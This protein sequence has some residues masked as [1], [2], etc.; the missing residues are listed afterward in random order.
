MQ[1]WVQTAFSLWEALGSSA[2]LLLIQSVR[3]DFITTSPKLLLH[4]TDYDKMQ[5]LDWFLKEWMLQATSCLDYGIVLMT[6]NN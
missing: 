5:A 1:I 3:D 4:L 2:T 6:L